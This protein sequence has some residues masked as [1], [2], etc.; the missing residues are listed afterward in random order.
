MVQN[1]HK[2]KCVI[3]NKEIIKMSEYI[4]NTVVAERELVYLIRFMHTE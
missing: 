1:L 4:K 3:T 2:W